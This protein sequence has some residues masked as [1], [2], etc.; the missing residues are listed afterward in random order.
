MALNKDKYRL[1]HLTAELLLSYKERQCSDQ[2]MHDIEKHLLDCELCQDALAGYEV[3]NSNEITADLGKLKS[4]LKSRTGHKTEHWK[5]LSV[6][7]SLALLITVG[8]L[9]FPTLEDPLTLEKKAEETEELKKDA[10]PSTEESIDNEEMPAPNEEIAKLVAEPALERRDVQSSSA[11]SA[12]A[13]SK[14]VETEEMEVVKEDDKMEFGAE[15]DAFTDEEVE[16]ERILAMES[17][18]VNGAPVSV[19]TQNENEIL[20]EEGPSELDEVVVQEYSTQK[21]SDIT[22]AVSVVDSDDASK[23]DKKSKTKARKSKKEKTSVR[24]ESI[25]EEAL[26]QNYRSNMK[27]TGAVQRATSARHVISGRIISAEDK[28][29]VPGVTV[30]IKNS[31]IGTVSDIDGF[32]SLEVPSLNDVLIFSFIGY[33]SIE[34][35]IGNREVINVEFLLDVESLEEVVVVGYGTQKKSAYN[36]VPSKPNITQPRPPGNYSEFKR[37]IDENLIYPEEALRKEIEG[38]VRLKFSVSSSGNIFDIQVVKSLGYGC[39]EEA[40]RLMKE[41]GKWQPGQVNGRDEEMPAT[42]TI[43][44]KIP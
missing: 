41:L 24:E 28:M 10:V 13:R 23:K 27:A 40:I 8:W 21:K 31:M 3:F 33:Q 36:E 17:A 15:E 14:V 2:E 18:K 44:F 20:D 6:A 38:R 19:P 7:A 43:R 29:E 9:L 16:K 4:N 26:E 22:G 39:D 34:V 5:Y 30:S 32:Y 1:T 11:P 25:E 12:P 42:Y 37:N 35:E